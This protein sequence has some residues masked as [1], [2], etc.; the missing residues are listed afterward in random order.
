[1][2]P[3]RLCSVYGVKCLVEEEAN[4]PGQVNPWRAIGIESWIVPQHGQNIGYYKTKSSERN[5]AIKLVDHRGD[6]RT[7]YA[8]HIRPA[9]VS[10]L[11]CHSKG[12]T[13]AMDIGKNLM[14]TFV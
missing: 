4:R 3:A 13:H 12:G 2:R 11:R 8:Y 10:V 9:S 6:L 5:L 7:Q 14:T 1:M